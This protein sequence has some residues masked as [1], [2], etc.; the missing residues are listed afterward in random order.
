MRQVDR[1]EV[2]EITR[3]KLGV[4]MNTAPEPDADFLAE[5]LRRA[6]AMI[7]P[8]RR[9]SIIHAALLPLDNLFTTGHVEYAA[10]SDML[11]RLI[12]IGDLT[13]LEIDGAREI[14]L[15]TPQRV[16]INAHDTVLLGVRPHGAPLVEPSEGIRHVRGL[17]IT[18]TETGAV[19]LLP[20]LSTTSWL[21]APHSA[22][23]ADVVAEFTSKLDAK[24][25]SGSVPE[26]NILDTASPVTHY[27]N[28]WRAPRQDDTGTFI[29]RR[30]KEFGARAW[31]F[32][33]LV[34]GVAT[35]LLDL[36][37]ASRTASPRDEAWRLQAAIDATNG[38][39]QLMTVA[40]DASGS[41]A[42]NFF[43]PVPAFALRFLETVAASVSAS[44]GA[45]I[46]YDVPAG[47]IDSITQF[48]QDHLWM[49]IQE[50]SSLRDR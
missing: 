33:A 43:G 38:A 50:G 34:D 5:T 39:P 24:G 18:S 7:A 46:T 23:A 28:R 45:L 15:G 16:K 8:A 22:S 35:K 40:H 11:E 47:R 6:A 41:A 30:P 12:A 19:S 9:A 4:P 32:C 26:L 29:A 25:D 2:I 10:A 27:A 20:E 31:S 14:Y 1:I 36:P 17:R 48:V 42:V 44:R 13:E 3:K 37:A 49:R 21:A